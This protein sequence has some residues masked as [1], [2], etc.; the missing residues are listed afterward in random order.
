[1]PV[2]KDIDKI[3]GE[4]LADIRKALQALGDPGGPMVIPEGAAN[5]IRN[6]LE[7]T[8]KLLIEERLVSLDLAEQLV[9]SKR[10]VQEL[11][12]ELETIIDCM[13]EDVQ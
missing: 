10:A 5:R 1:M 9:E 12:E 13:G 8:H 7:A 3:E 2:K 4:V 11:T 6:I